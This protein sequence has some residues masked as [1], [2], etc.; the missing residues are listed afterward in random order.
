[1]AVHHLPRNGVGQ[2]MQMDAQRQNISVNKV[3]STDP[4][5]YDNVP[6]A[7]LSDYFFVWLRRPLKNIYPELYATLAT[8]KIEELVAFAYRHKDGKP[9]AEKF[10]LDGMTSAMQRLAEQAHPS[11]PVTIYYAFKQAETDDSEQTSSTGWVTFLEAVI[12]AGFSITPNLAN[13]N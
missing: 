10:F 4:P 5:Y 13:E 1:M 3:V 11:F 8:P 6:Y 2:V 7:D 9:G 12:R